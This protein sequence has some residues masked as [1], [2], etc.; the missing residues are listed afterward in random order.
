MAWLPDG[1]KNIED[2]FIRF[3]QNIRTWQ[4]H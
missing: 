1:E 3:W 4:T 2:I